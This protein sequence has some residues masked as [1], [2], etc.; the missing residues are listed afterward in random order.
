MIRNFL[1][2]YFHF[3]RG[4][5][6]GTLVLAAVM[7]GM[8]AYPHIHGF[9]ARPS[10]YP[11]DPELIEAIRAFYTNR[12]N[13]PGQEPLSPE[14]PQ[15]L[16]TSSEAGIKTAGDATQTA[17]I[18]LNSADTAD[19][20][21]VSGI[22]PVLSRRILRYRDILG[23]FSSVEQLKEIYGL[24]EDRYMLIN[25]FFYARTDCISRI[26]PLHDD[27]GVL[28]RHPY[29]DFDQVSQIFRLRNNENLRSIEDLLK[30]SAFSEPDVDR[31][32]PYLDFGETQ[33]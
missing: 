27:F 19:L 7:L 5:V 33:N 18:D 1:R 21:Q 29:L 8:F 12:D 28:L 10:A 25:H 17:L 3:T 13:P 24:D 16:L 31:L 26:R 30:T 14:S 6:N 22:G 20:M 11:V 15:A 9:L 23:G 2:E 4:E 32:R